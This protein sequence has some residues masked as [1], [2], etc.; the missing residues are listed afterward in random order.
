VKAPRFRGARD[1]L[2]GFELEVAEFGVGV[3]E[4]TQRNEFAASLLDRVDDAFL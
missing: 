3:N 1:R 4:V 2:G